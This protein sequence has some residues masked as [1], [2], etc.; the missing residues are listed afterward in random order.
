VAGGDVIQRVGT[1]S[2]QARGSILW[3]TKRTKNWSAQWLAKVRQDQRDAKADVAVIVST[4][5]PDGVEHF[6]LIDGVW[7]CRWPYAKGL[8]SALRLGILDS[9]SARRAGEGKAG[10]MERVYNYLAS[11]EFRNRI[12]GLV[13]ALGTTQEDLD[14]ERRALQKQWAKREKLIQQAGL[15]TVGIYGDLQGIVGRVLPEIEGADIAQL[16]GH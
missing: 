11:Q 10:K 8:A 5:M 12:T 16:E 7:V 14:K 1:E 13:D 2:G 9:A 3:E 4:A 6:D 15:E